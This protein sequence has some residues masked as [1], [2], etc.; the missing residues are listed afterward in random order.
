MPRRSSTRTSSERSARAR[1][2]AGRGRRVFNHLVTPS[3]T[4]IAHGVRDLAEYAGVSEGESGPS[5][6][7]S[8]PTGSA[9]VDGRYEI[10]TTCSPTQ[11][12]AWRIRHEAERARESAPQRPTGGTGASG[13]APASSLVG[14]RGD[15]GG[16]YL[17]ADPAR[18]RSGRGGARTGERARQ[19]SVLIPVAP[20]E[21]DPEFGLLLAAEAARLRRGAAS[22]T[23]SGAHC[24]CRT[25]VASCP[26]VGLPF[27]SFSGARVVVGTAAG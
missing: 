4:K 23:C 20:V 25:C 3:G 1:P 15:D 24:S 6:P 11:C 10:F 9:A 21:A 27:A 14:G 7:R 17:C 8:A 16:D 22:P 2:G 18:R 19:A 5:W 13:R 12:S 26:S